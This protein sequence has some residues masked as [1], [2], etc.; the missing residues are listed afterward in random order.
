MLKNIILAATTV[1][2][3]STGV[4]QAD[5]WTPWDQTLSSLIQDKSVGEV[6]HGNPFDANSFDGSLFPIVESQTSIENVESEY[7]GITKTVVTSVEITANET[8]RVE[9]TRSCINITSPIP[10]DCRPSSFH[11][12]VDVPDKDKVVHWEN[13]LPVLVY[14]NSGP[15]V[16]FS[17]TLVS[18]S[19]PYYIRVDS[20]TTTPV[21]ILNETFHYA[22]VDYDT[23]E[24]AEAAAAAAAPTDPTDPVGP[25]D[26]TDEDAE[27]VAPV[28]DYRALAA[29]DLRSIVERDLEF[30][31]S[32]TA[33]DVF[34]FTHEINT[35]AAGYTVSL[36][37]EKNYKTT[38]HDLSAYIEPRVGLVG[39]FGKDYVG[40][41]TGA[42]YG[43]SA[44]SL[45]GNFKTS[46]G[47]DTG[48][49]YEIKGDHNGFSGLRING[50]TDSFAFGE[51]AH[52]SDNGL[53]SSVRSDTN[54]VTTFK[55]SNGLFSFSINDEAKAQ[56]GINL[57]F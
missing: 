52:T 54:G 29:N 36:K 26:P 18:G 17:G 37:L 48:E 47:L 4:A 53:T 7:E 22:G 23:K 9:R 24:E 55:T 31:N 38:S 45:K 15:S 51:V 1:T 56:A 2:A 49:H 16:S 32:L 43:A 20:Y 28:I 21:G 25:T 3:L 57:K 44:K 5:Q 14:L 46:F 10:D 41:H 12:F 35:S 30:S 39:I 11:Q 19:N 40:I 27:V 42:E 34:G 50:K 8:R 6:Q 33:K 13:D